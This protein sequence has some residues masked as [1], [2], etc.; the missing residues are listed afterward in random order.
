MVIMQK[1]FP[2]Y[3]LSALQLQKELM[4]TN[5]KYKLKDCLNDHGLK[6]YLVKTCKNDVCNFIDCNYYTFDQFNRK[7]NNLMK[8][9]KNIEL[10]I[11]HLNIQSLNSKITGFRQLMDLVQLDFDV[12]VLSEIWMYNIDFYCN[13]F[14]GYSFHYDL[15]KD[16]N[17]GGIGIYVKG[18]IF[19]QIRKDLQL[20]TSESN[21]L[22]NIWIEVNKGKTKYI[23]GGIYRHPSNNI[24]DFMN[25]LGSNL[26]IVS[27]GNTPCFI[28]GDI[29]ID[30]LKFEDHRDTM[31][32]VN[33]L[34]LHCCLPVQL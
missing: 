16:S 28:V 7:I 1:S 23:I 3:H 27:Q 30:L 24:I 20:N 5:D 11:M 17:V 26:K 2:F 4:I 31:Q 9:A 10:S 29:N 21:R 6:E 32:Y 18:T 14:E 12:L 13:V 34:L 22:E 15:P 8:T 33:Q 19:N 25:L